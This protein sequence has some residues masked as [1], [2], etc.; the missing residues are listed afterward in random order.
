MRERRS[1]LSTDDGSI[2]RRAVQLEGR[3]DVTKWGLE[4]DGRIL[5][6]LACYFRFGDWKQH[7]LDVKEEEE[8]YG[9]ANRRAIDS[10]LLLY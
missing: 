3:M 7:K 8:E 2:K 1:E 4:K 9:R 5:D 6:H 10:K